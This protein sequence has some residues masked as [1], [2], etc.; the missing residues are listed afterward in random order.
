ELHVPGDADGRGT[1]PRDLDCRLPTAENA[2]ERVLAYRQR[3]GGAVGQDQLSMLPGGHARRAVL[4][5]AD[6]RTPPRDWRNGAYWQHRDGAALGARNDDVAS[7]MDRR[8]GEVEDLRSVPQRH[9][10]TGDLRRCG[11]TDT[12][13]QMGLV[14]GQQVSFRLRA[15]PD[16]RLPSH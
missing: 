8:S 14:A 10:L 2:T 4:L 7:P 9:S 16:P 11:E 12:S 15:V 3:G 6:V 13:P 5:A 1:R